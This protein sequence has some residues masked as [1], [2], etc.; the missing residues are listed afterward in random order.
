MYRVL[1]GWSSFSTMQF[2]RQSI[3]TQIWGI[4]YFL[5][6]KSYAYLLNIEPSNSV[7]LKTYNIEFD[8]IIITFTDQNGRPLEIEDKVN[9]HLLINRN[10]MLFYRSKNKKICQRIWIFVI[11]EK[12]IWQIWENIITY[13]TKAGL[14]ALKS[15]SKKVAHKTAAATG[16][17]I[18]NKI[19]NKIVKK[20]CAWCE[21]KKY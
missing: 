12:S 15:V 21:L 11:L 6:T 8:K 2:S 7:F 18:G 16:K 4:I 19:A 17:L 20:T 10:S 1:S 9:Y 14:N 13:A 5:S 3:S